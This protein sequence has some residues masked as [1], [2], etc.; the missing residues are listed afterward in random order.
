MGG[1]SGG[2]VFGKDL[3]DDRRFFLVAGAGDWAEAGSGAASIT[4]KPP[5][6]NRLN[7][8]LMQNTS[9]FNTNPQR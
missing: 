6:R 7:S 2:G 8:R 5:V 9:L 3:R 1:I 4:S